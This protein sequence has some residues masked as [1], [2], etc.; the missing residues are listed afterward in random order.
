MEGKR[1]EEIRFLEMKLA[2]KGLIRIVQLFNKGEGNVKQ[3]ATF[4]YF[5]FAYFF[6]TPHLKTHLHLTLSR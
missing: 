6:S 3:L 4:S 5:V 1:R 2:N